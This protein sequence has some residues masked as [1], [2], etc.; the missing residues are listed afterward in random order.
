M[1]LIIIIARSGKIADRL[2]KANFKIPPLHILEETELDQKDV[3]KSFNG[4]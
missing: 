1:L 2:L 4:I 3:K